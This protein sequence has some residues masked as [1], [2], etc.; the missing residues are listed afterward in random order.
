MDGAFAMA[1]LPIRYEITN[2]DEFAAELV[3]ALNDEDEQGTT[4][5]HKM[6]DA[7]IEYAVDQ[8]ALGITEHGDQEL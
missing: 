8:G 1:A 5:V 2:F 7:A 3:R 4:R 6:F